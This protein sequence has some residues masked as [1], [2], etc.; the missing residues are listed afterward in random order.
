MPFTENL[1]VFINADTPGY[2]L[3]TVGGVSVAALFDNEYAA[4]F[5]IDGSGPALTVASAS[6]PSAAQGDAVVVGGVSYTVAAIRPDGTG[7]SV[8]RLLEA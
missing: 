8:L 5:D 2:V 3:A 1:A 4:A 6:V 7:A